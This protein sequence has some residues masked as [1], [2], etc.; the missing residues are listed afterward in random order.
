MSVMV[1]QSTERRR[2]VLQELVPTTKQVVPLR[3]P[4]PRLC[5]QS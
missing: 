2:A 5:L 3:P 4:A 1:A